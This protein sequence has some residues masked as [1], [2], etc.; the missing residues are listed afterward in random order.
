MGGHNKET[1]HYNPHQQAFPQ[2]PASLE[3][4]QKR[5]EEKR[6]EKSKLYERFLCYVPHLKKN[7]TN[8]LRTA[9]YFYCVQCSRLTNSRN[10]ITTNMRM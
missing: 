7:T 4:S 1:L 5:K 9:S 6:K 10:I 2:T 3:R 8:L